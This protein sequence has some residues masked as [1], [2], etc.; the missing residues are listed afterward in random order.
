MKFASLYLP[1]PP[2]PHAFSA[3]PP[4]RQAGPVGVLLV[5]LGTPDTPTPRDIRRY[6]AEFLSDR[7]VIEI[8]PWIWQ[9]V[10][11]LFILPKRP[12]AL[13]PRYR[14]IWLEDGSPLL[15]WSQAQAEA[16]QRE[17]SGQGQ[18]V[19]VRLGM[20]YGNPSIAQALDEL[21]ADG[22]ERI[23]TVPMYPQYAAST[24]ATAVDHVARHAARLRNQPELRFLKRFHDDPGYIDALAQRLQAHWAAAG[25]PERLLLSFHGLPR[26]SVEQGDPYHRDCMETASLLK[27]RLGADGGLVHVGFQSRFGAAKWLEPYTEPTL[28][29]WARQGVRRVDV[30]C[31]GFLAD[32]LET[33]EEI[34]VECRDAFLEEGGEQLRYVPCLNDDAEWSAAFARLIRKHLAGWS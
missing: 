7:R 26:F 34:S 32:C 30:M 25:R 13:A 29:A 23:L 31:P 1:E 19:R 28:R 10:L 17:L 20:R 9:A 16:V 22:C 5:N 27:R 6:L 15:V 24:T 8:P 21:R 4:P 11:R 18:A 2:D 3:D 12:R 33:L 14:D